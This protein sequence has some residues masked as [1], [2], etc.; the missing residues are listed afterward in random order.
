M[1][2]QAWEAEAGCEPLWLETDVW[3]YTADPQAVSLKC[4][5]S[6]GRSLR[7][8]LRPLNNPAFP[9]RLLVTSP[10]NF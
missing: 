1:C 5:G 7:D 6:T 3:V 8:R 4:C 9:G 2:R 10:D